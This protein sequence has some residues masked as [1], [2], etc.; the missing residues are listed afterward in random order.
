MKIMYSSVFFGGL[1][2]LLIG[3]AAGHGM[4]VDPPNRS[5]LWRFDP[6]FPVNWDDNQNYCGGFTVSKFC[7]HLLELDDFKTIRLRYIKFEYFSSSENFELN[8]YSLK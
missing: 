2:V 3:E 1:A 6:S 8:L 4:L 7:V 5:S